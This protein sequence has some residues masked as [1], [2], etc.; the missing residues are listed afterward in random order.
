MTHE[1][2]KEMEMDFLYLW[3]DMIME[4]GDCVSTWEDVF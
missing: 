2:H 4:Y 3:L 1:E